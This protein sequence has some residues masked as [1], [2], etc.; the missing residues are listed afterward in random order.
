M[1]FLGSRKVKESLEMK[2]EINDLITSNQLHIAESM[3]ACMIMSHP[4]LIILPLPM[5]LW[6]ILFGIKKQGSI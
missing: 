4:L 1:P 3:G 6:T 2:L 5:M